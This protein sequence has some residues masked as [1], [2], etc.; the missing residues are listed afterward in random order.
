MKIHGDVPFNPAQVKATN[1]YE[2]PF[3]EKDE[4]YTYSFLLQED[5]YDSTKDE[6]LRAK[7]IEEAKLLYGEFKPSGPQKPL[8]TIS[9]SRL[10]EIVECLKRLLLSDWND[11]NFV[12]GTNPN[13]LIEIKFDMNTVDT[14][15]GLHAYMNTMLNTNDEVIRFQL[16]KLPR[17]WGYREENFVYYMLTPPWVK[18]YVND[19][20][21]QTKASNNRTALMMQG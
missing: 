2:Y 21:N 15:Q 3:L 19:V 12:I 5:P 17:Y 11:V 10:E 4:Q 20:T 8:S 18:L 1:K 13:D 6:K 9:K 7:W 16:R 14:L